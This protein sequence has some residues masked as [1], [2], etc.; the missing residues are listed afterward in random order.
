MTNDH[1]VMQTNGYKLPL[2]TSGHWPACPILGFMLPGILPIIC[3]CLTFLRVTEAV[4]KPPEHPQQRRKKGDNYQM[5]SDSWFQFKT[6]PR[7][8]KPSPFCIHAWLCSPCAV[9]QLD[10]AWGPEW[11]SITPIHSWIAELGHTDTYY[12]TVWEGGPNSS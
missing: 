8:L 9:P 1:I 12:A 6:R 4:T 11:H 3:L 7:S 2:F 5:F 10:R